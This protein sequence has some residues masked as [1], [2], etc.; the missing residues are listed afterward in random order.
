MD[1]YLIASL[2]VGGIILVG[3]IVLVVRSMPP[4]VSTDRNALKRAETIIHERKDQPPPN[5]IGAA[6]GTTGAAIDLAKADGKG[7]GDPAANLALLEAE[8][9]DLAART[10]SV[11]YITLGEV[12]FPALA[13]VLEFARGRYPDLGEVQAPA[14]TFGQ[15]PFEV[16][17]GK[18]RFHIT[19]LS[20]P[21]PWRGLRDACSHA[22]WWP[23][24]TRAMKHHVGAIKLELVESV[25]R[26]DH[27]GNIVTLTALAAC[28]GEVAQGT[29]FY[30]PAGRI[31]HPTKTLL[32]LVDAIPGGRIPI[33]LWV[34]VRDYVDPDGSQGVETSGMMLFINREVETEPKEEVSL[35]DA[36]GQA[37]D[38]ISYILEHESTPGHGSTLNVG[39]G[40]IF[41]RHAMSRHNATLPVLNLEAQ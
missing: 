7:D 12:T 20:E 24:A 31:V 35:T 11:A 13:E 27:I 33:Q 39:S 17:I 14:D 2:V 26:A 9:Q 5:F 10:R 32:A 38:A 40:R 28:V 29:G 21:L 36:R 3:I 25:D 22:R 1:T 19:Y 34:D 23:E 16:N 37:R 8:E 15:G 41:V 30:W 18:G 4:R 6:G